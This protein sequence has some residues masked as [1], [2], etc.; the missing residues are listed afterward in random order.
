MSSSSVSVLRPSRLGTVDSIGGDLPLAP[1]RP[2][3]PRGKKQTKPT[4]RRP[5]PV[6]AGSAASP[7]PPSPEI[8]PAAFPRRFSRAARDGEEDR[9]EPDLSVQRSP[10]I[11]INQS[12]VAESRFRMKTVSQIE[13]LPCKTDLRRS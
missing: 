2:G 3:T 13:R 5:R 12:H 10:E 9:S 4:L 7:L 11:E 6:G 8:A 1:Y